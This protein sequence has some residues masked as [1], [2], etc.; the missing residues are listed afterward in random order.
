MEKPHL[1]VISVPRQG[2]QVS[3]DVSPFTLGRGADNTLSLPDPTISSHHARIVEH[4]G[5]YWLEDLGSTNGTYFL[6][7]RGEEFRLAKDK[8]VLLVE[9]ARIRL[10]GHTT[11]QVEGMVA[12]QQDATAWSLQQ[13][14]AFIT[15]CYEGLTALEPAQRQ[16]A[17][18]DLCRLEDNIRQANS[19]AELVHLVAEKLSALT[20][21]VVCE[22]MPDE[23]GLPA[24][25][26][27]LPEPDSPF[28]VPSLHNLFLSNL[29]HILQELPGQ[30]EKL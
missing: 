1:T 4:I 25:P 19:E 6:P 11:L 18:D 3:M 26:K 12:S 2:M 10:G 5:L 27:D 23:S 8:P 13:L 7:P 17:L 28:R 14:Q 24:L 9:G 15:G 22:Y 20:K 16:V 21:T 30:E 29:R